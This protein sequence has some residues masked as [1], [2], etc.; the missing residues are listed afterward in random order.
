MK[1]NIT[2]CVFAIAVL[3]GSVAVLHNK[4]SQH[5]AGLKRITVAQY[6]DVFLYMPL[7]VAQD[8]GFF[9]TNGLHVSIVSTGGDDKTFAAVA[10]GSAMF[11]I[12]DPAFAAI[13]YEKGFKGKVLGSIV[14]GVPFWGVTD[15]PKYV[16]I[17]TPEQFKRLR[18]ATFP[19]PSTAYAMQSK[20]IKDVGAE[21]SIVQIAFG[22]GLQA[23]KNQRVD[24]SLELEPN[25]SLA[26]KQGSYVSYSMASMYKDFVFTGVTSSEKNIEQNPEI[27]NCFM[28]SINQALQYI[29]QNPSN[30]VQCMCRRFKDVPQDVADSA[31]QRLL[32]EGTIPETTKVSNKAWQNSLVL[33]EELGDL[34]SAKNGLPV[35][36]PY[37]EEWE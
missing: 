17:K 31:L 23:L 9:E 1:K 14:N 22:G 25:V 29:H 24:V 30:A 10:S 4:M 5:D 13:A 11:G 37:N 35:L 21:A 12:A 33:R 26:L 28:R 27:V 19:A 7:Y 34:K 2:I 8:C 6:G 3:V 15:N 18:I 16:D 20:M 36:V 32:K